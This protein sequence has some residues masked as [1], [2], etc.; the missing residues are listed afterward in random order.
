ML[1]RNNICLLTIFLVSCKPLEVV[2]TSKGSYKEELYLKS[3][4][5][6]FI[7]DLASEKRQWD[8]INVGDT[9]YLHRESLKIID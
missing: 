5:N 3:K 1:S 6:K 9:I 7:Y 4:D 2:V 8:K